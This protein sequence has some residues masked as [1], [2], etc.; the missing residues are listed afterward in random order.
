[1]RRLAD[2]DEERP[3]QKNTIFSRNGITGSSARIVKCPAAQLG[4]DLH[5]PNNHLSNKSKL[6]EKK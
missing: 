3:L 2:V 6:S 1:M 5:S 4:Q